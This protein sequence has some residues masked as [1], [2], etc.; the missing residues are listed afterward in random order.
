MPTPDAR[1]DE[2]A[3]ALAAGNLAPV[4]GDSLP[5]PLFYPRDAG[6]EQG[7]DPSPGQDPRPYVNRAERI[8]APT[9][10]NRNA[11][12]VASA[13]LIISTTIEVKGMSKSVTT[14]R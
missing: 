6:G 13:H 5:H 8:H 4:T 2:L 10:K 9:A 14:T 12:I 3:E 11:G 7:V 1:N